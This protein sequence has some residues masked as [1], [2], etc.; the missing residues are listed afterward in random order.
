[1][2]IFGT[3]CHLNDPS[4]TATLPDVIERAKAAGVGSI[5][6]PAYGMEALERAAQLAECYLGLLFPAYGFHPWFIDER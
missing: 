3:H 2:D 5:L 4:L 1:M 6:V